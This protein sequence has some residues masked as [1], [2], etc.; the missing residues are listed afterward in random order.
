MRTYHSYHHPTGCLIYLCNLYYLYVSHVS[1]CIHSHHSVITRTFRLPSRA[2]PFSYTERGDLCRLSTLTGGFTYCAL[3]FIKHM[4]KPLASVFFGA[5]LGFLSLIP[6]QALT[7][8]AAYRAC[9]DT[10]DT[11]TLVTVRAFAGTAEYC[12]SNVYL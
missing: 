8:A 2:S 6:L 4:I 9:Q 5:T 12:V 3:Y 11:H 7:N 10:P 1:N